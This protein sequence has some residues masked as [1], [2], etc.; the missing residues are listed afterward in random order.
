MDADI[1]GISANRFDWV[2][3]SQF[4]THR[5]PE[6]Y[7]EPARFIPERWFS[8]EPNQYEY[9]PFSAGPRWCIGKPLA[10]MTLKLSLSMILQR[11]RL[12]MQ[13]GARIDRFVRVTMRPKHGL[14]MVLQPHLRICGAEPICGNI[15]EL[16]D[17]TGDGRSA[18][19]TSEA[20]RMAA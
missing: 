8:F 20:R 7:P 17:W 16:V 9:F 10:T 1:S 11:W 14:P 6:L 19:G 3:L 5:I 4:L 15:V 2:L 18:I 12:Q 13:P